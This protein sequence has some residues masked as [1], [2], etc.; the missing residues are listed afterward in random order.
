MALG[1]V[2]PRIRLLLGCHSQGFRLTLILLKLYKL[3]LRLLILL[4]L[5]QIQ[6]WNNFLEHRQLLGLG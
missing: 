1:E 5:I 4:N 3:F 6:V 2:D